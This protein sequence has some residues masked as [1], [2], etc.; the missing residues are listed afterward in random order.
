M[1][2]EEV[3]RILENRMIQEVQYL[4]WLAN[5]V[6]VSKNNGKIRVCI[7]FI[8]LN[9]ACPKNSFPLLHIDRIVDAT[10]RH[11]ML[12]FFRHLLGV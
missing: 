7:S 9:K 6:V 5:L 4:E 1:V 3:K 12:S 2:N 11:E 10:A 8:D